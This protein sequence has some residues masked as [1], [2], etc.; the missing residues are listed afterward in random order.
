MPPS[1]MSV[2]TTSATGSSTRNV[3]RCRST[4]KL[5][6]GSAGQPARER[7]QRGDAG[8]RRHELQPHQRA[9]LREVAHRHFAG[10]VL[11]V[12]VGGERGGGVEDQVA[13]DRALAVGIERQV[14]LQRQDAEAH[15]RT[16]PR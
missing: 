3:A 13:G 10:I 9:E 12:G 11:Q 2:A 16:S 14:L 8:R 1:T 15:R 7:R 4:K 6:S 5:P